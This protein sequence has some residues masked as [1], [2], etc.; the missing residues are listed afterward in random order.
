[1]GDVEKLGLGQH[2]LWG[3]TPALDLLA[4]RPSSSSSSSSAPSP[5]E[6]QPL[7]ILLANPNDIRHV[8][9]T[10][11]CRHRHKLPGKN[12]IPPINVSLKSDVLFRRHESKS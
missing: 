3:F 1:M 7:N 4:L 9:N 6:E 12:A 2:A 8:L 5:G 10:I 11:A